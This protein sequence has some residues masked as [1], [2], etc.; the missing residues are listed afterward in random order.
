MMKCVEAIEYVRPMRG[1]SHPHLLRCSDGGYYVVKFQSNVHGG[2]ILANEL[3][4]STLAT[5][6]LLPVPEFALVYVGDEMVR[7]CEKGAKLAGAA[8]LSNDPCPTRLCFGSRLPSCDDALVADEP[9]DTPDSGGYSFTRVENARDFLG[10]LVFDQWTCNRDTR[11]VIYV[12][13]NH[14]SQLK[15]YMIDEGCCFGNTWRFKDSPFLGLYRNPRTYS[16]VQG[17]SSFDPWLVIVE[18]AITLTALEAAAM[19]IPSQ[20]YQDDFASLSK[21][22]ETLDRR[23]RRIRGLLLATLAARPKWFSVASATLPIRVSS[24]VSVS[25]TTS[26]IRSQ[27]RSETSASK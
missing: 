9:F 1:R 12:R 25:K 22:L 15:V 17:V 19:Q 6:M 23:R 7:F 26:S 13:T 4:G 10:M 18:K 3:L 11:Q 16:T 5:H 21:L 24:L 27:V 14:N 20:W 2:R 8:E